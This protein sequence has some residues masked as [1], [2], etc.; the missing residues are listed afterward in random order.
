MSLVA[1]KIKSGRAFTIYAL[2]DTSGC[3]LLDFLDEIGEVGKAK[4][5]R[6]LDFMKEHGLFRNKEKSKRLENGI[7]YLRTRQGTRVFYF[8]DKGQLIFFANGYVKKKDKLD[9]A[10]MKKAEIWRLKYEAARDAQ[11]LKY[12]DQI[13]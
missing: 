2:E 10:E 7:S 3:P 4:I 6:D 9:P 11:T 13:I 8:T 12:R 1:V 5:T